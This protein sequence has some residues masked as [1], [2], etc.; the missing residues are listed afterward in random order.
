MKKKMENNADRN[1][2]YL[3]SKRV[4]LRPLLEEDFT[5]EYLSWLNDPVVNEYSQKRPFPVGWERM[6]SYNEYYLKNPQEG[7]VLAIIDKNKKSH[8]GNIALVNIQLVN[9]C[10]EITIL[11]GNKNYWNR[12]YGAECMYLLTKHAFNEMNLNKIFA[13]SFNPAFVRSVEKIGWDKEG[14]FKERIWCNG[15]YHNQVWMS[16]LRSKFKKIGAYENK[17]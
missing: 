10:A 2:V 7:F 11:M 14:E 4:I 12:G 15:K 5:L 13:G 16:I 9:R 6:K 1:L 8:I 3:S 17:K